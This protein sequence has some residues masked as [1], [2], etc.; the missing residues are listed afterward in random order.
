MAKLIAEGYEL[1]EPGNYK[2]E[3]LEAALINE[4]QPQIRLRLRVVAGENKDFVFTDFANRGSE[5]GVRVGTKSFEIF[6]A[7]L[8]RRPAASDEL[9]TDDLIG[10]RF[11][12]R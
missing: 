9:D 8:N 10:K 11:E 3:V 6:E 4:F 2:L 5:N 12:A 1:L 7:C